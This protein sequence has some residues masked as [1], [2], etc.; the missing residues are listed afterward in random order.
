MSNFPRD[1]GDTGRAIAA[2]DWAST[3]LGPM[4]SWP[5]ALRSTVNLMLDSPFAI[6]I[7]WGPSLTFLHNDSC[8]PILGQ[9][10]PTAIG[11]PIKDV[12]WD[13]WDFI[14]PWI[15]QAMGGKAVQLEDSPL[16][17]QRNGYPEETWWT[18]AYSPLADGDGTVHGFINICIETTGKVLGQRQVAQEQARLRQLFDKAPAFMALMTGPEHRFELVNSG[19]QK[20]VGDRDVIGKTLTEALGEAVSQG[21]LEILDQTYRTGE[22]YF[23]EGARLAL[24]LT[25]GGPIVERYLDFVY[26]PLRDQNGDV[27]GIF[28]NGVDVTERRQRDQDRDI[29]HREMVHRLKNTMAVTSAVVSASI[30]HASS[31]EEAKATVASRIEALSRSHDMLTRPEGD[32]EIEAIVREAI[33]P[34]VDRW[35]R[36]SID[37]PHVLIS[38]EQAV[39]L[40][41][42]LHELATNALKYGALS[43][44]DGRVS[45]SWSM[46]DGPEFTF[47]WRESDGPVTVAPLKKG[48]GSRL[49]NQIVPSYF[50]GTGETRFEPA[51]VEYSLKGAISPAIDASARS[52]EAL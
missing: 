22:P 15:E 4:E 45:I 5:E 51:G 29:L 23:G 41:L 47:R 40:A 8:I 18:F 17:M 11:K 39:G 32:A 21:Y 6:C 7:A 26:Q 1:G 46:R 49:I 28:V 34:H 52:E 36:I 25:K 50:S 13:I 38:S 44:P 12:W 20:L 14:G 3:E 24:P 30:R 43:V 9:R 31:L 33:S 19:Y 48:F 27:Y 35:D 42:A 2:F 16:M 37:G 10:A